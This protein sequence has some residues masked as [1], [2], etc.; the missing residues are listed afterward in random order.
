ML[1]ANLQHI[2]IIVLL[3]V[4]SLP[5]IIHLMENGG[6]GHIIVIALCLQDVAIL[7]PVLF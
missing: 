6:Q 5:D 1:T 2:V 7:T 4:H 3:I